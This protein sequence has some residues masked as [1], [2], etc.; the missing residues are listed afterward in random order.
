MH[1]KLLLIV[2]SGHFSRHNPLNKYLYSGSFLQSLIHF[3]L[4]SMNLFTSIG[5]KGISV[6]LYCP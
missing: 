1:I 6:H 4:L 3:F 5:Q 2:F